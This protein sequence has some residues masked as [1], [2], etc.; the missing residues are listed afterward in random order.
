[1][2]VGV[3]AAVGVSQHVQQVRSHCYCWWGVVRSGNLVMK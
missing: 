2:H 3:E 1:V